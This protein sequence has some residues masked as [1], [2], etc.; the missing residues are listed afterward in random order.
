LDNNPKQQI[1]NND[2]NELLRCRNTRINAHHNQISVPKIT[3]RAPQLHEPLTILHCVLEHDRALK[4]VSFEQQAIYDQL[5][6]AIN[7][8]RHIRTGSSNALDGSERHACVSSRRDESFHMELVL[9]ISED[10]I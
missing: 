1:D 9:A 5:V 7:F 6:L 2:K 10:R 4:V 8:N 3:K